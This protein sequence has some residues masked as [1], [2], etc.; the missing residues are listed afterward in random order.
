M[1]QKRNHKGNQKILKINKTKNTTYQN[2]WDKVKVVRRG[3]FKAI[4]A[5]T[6]K[7]E[8]LQINN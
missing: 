6:K 1:D 4:K 2:V 8:R 7:T 5:Y 3:K